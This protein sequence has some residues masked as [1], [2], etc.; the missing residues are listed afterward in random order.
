MSDLIK[1]YEALEHED[2]E[3][4]AEIFKKNTSLDLLAVVPGKGKSVLQK[5]WELDHERGD[6]DFSD[7]VLGVDTLSESKFE[8]Y[9]KAYDKITNSFITAGSVKANASRNVA[10]AGP[11]P[12]NAAAGAPGPARLNALNATLFPA[13]GAVPPTVAPS[14]TNIAKA[15][16]FANLVTEFLNSDSFKSRDKVLTFLRA[17]IEFNPLIIL[18]EFKTS[19]WHLLLEREK[20][21]I[22]YSLILNFIENFYKLPAYNK[23]FTFGSSISPTP[24]AKKL[25]EP[26]P[27]Q[28]E[29]YDALQKTRDDFIANYNRPSEEVLYAKKYFFQLAQN[30]LKD[31]LETP[32]TFL[33]VLQKF[34]PEYLRSKDP[35]TKVT[36]LFPISSI[37]N[38]PITDEKDTLLQKSLEYIIPVQPLS[39][40]CTMKYKSTPNSCD[41]VL[42]LEGY[43]KTVSYL[44]RTGRV[45]ELCIKQLVHE[46]YNKIIPADKVE[47]LITPLSREQFFEFYSGPRMGSTISITISIILKYPDQIPLLFTKGIFGMTS[48]SEV[49]YI[50]T[51]LYLAA[52]NDIEASFDIL[53]TNLGADIN[54][55]DKGG[56]SL[57]YHIL[58]YADIKYAQ[59]LLENGANPNTVGSIHRGSTPT[60]PYL[61][62]ARLLSHGDDKR[63]PLLLFLL[64]LPMFD[65]DI[66]IQIVKQYLE[67]LD[68]GSSEKPRVQE[69]Y[70]L[71]VKTKRDSVKYRGYTQSQLRELNTI[72]EKPADFSM[73]PVCLST[74]IR[75]EGC[76]YMTHNCSTLGIPYH[77]ELYEKYKN[78]D[79]DITWCTM[80]SRIGMSR[81]VQRRLVT[82]EWVWQSVHEHLQLGSVTGPK[83]PPAPLQGPENFFDRD[84]VQQGGGGVLE[85]Y[86][87][88]HRL[89][90]FAYDL[91]DEIG[92]VSAWDARKELIEQVWN[93]PL[94]SNR[95]AK[96]VKDELEHLFTTEILPVATARRNAKVA[97]VTAAAG[98]PAPE[99]SILLTPEEDAR[100]NSVWS[101]YGKATT[102][103]PER[104]VMEEANRV[105][106]QA[107]E[108]ALLERAQANIPRPNAA[109]AALQPIRYK[110]KMEA[111]SNANMANVCSICQLTEKPR[112]AFQHKEPNGTVQSHTDMPICEDCLT[113]AITA[114]LAEKGL[115]S[116]GHC[117]LYPGCKALFWP[118]E[119]QGKIPADLYEAYRVEF[120]K[121][122]LEGSLQGGMRG[123]K[124]QPTFQVGGVP[125]LTPMPTGSVTCTAANG[126]TPTTCSKCKT[127][128]GGRRKQQR[129]KRTQKQ[130]RK[131]TQ[132]RR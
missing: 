79:G 76:L 115:P 110:A 95:R 14:N 46:L 117:W 20:A 37:V 1:L 43:Y 130:R 100:L 34:T 11:S 93:A 68:A 58:F 49:H 63:A 73:C 41:L 33:S 36:A 26:T 19:L 24:N 102:N 59:K 60:T 50:I 124:R 120:N 89:R 56:H 96:K 128:R 65:L 123:G 125:F 71:L 81:K 32:D 12:A 84:C 54:L 80:C 72:V 83:P 57:F 31:A 90:E 17:N 7:A 4:A 28:K 51:P 103:F 30:K 85:K 119:I 77:E 10:G 40:V 107:K 116:F 13:L 22:T 91:Q 47:E 44:I 67:G 106:A 129:R 105:V 88:L 101:K 131:R 94:V 78:V 8:R 109:N 61:E 111:N 118:Q 6:E 3:V 132:K 99:L 64:D 62:V 112:W 98:G 121:K 2:P 35:L 69:A 66:N 82:G 113:N 18:P 16:E 75:S 92:K 21:N 70:D 29:I 127:R 104:N 38:G 55:L 52:R 45:S 97:E 39:E 86:M 5:I 74:A 87:R 122:I 27:K 23:V 53:L 126:V 15:R 108:D 48:L 114:K 9:T 42:L 25:H